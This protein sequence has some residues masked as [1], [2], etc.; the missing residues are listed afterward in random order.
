MTIVENV[1]TFYCSH[2]CNIC[3]SSP[4]A[5]TDFPLQEELDEIVCNK[6]G[7]TGF[8]KSDGWIKQEEDK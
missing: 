5:G 6:C 8:T 4:I 7:K 3:F 1:E 2:G